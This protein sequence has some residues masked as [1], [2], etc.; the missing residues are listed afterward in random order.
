MFL[1]FYKKCMKKRLIFHF[2]LTDNWMMQKTNKIH[3]CCLK[4]FANLFNEMTFVV[5]IDD[6]THTDLIYGFEDFIIKLKICTNIKFIVKSNTI[7]RDSQT[8]YDEI[9]LKLKE[10]DGLTFFAHNKGLT[11][12]D[13][14]AFKKENV[15]KWITSM[16]YGCLIRPE[17]SEYEL[18]DG[19]KVSY[20]TLFDIIKDDYGHREQLNLHL[21][22]RW[23]FYM[24]T[25]FWLNC[26][27][28]DGFL[29]R[30]GKTVPTITDRWYAENF[31][32][33]IIDEKHC[34]SFDTRYM[35]D[36]LGGGWGE[37]DNVLLWSFG[38]YLEEY[39]NFHNK[40]LENI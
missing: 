32:A 22:D 18:T 14:S 36:Y 29:R 34:G 33:N 20:G 4:Y 21:G 37:M 31:L 8:F 6:L 9:V 15:E 40:I 23:F 17:E 11:N 2:Y 28:I 24:G 10:L 38:P 35:I 25:F 5:V 26:G 12:Y 13:D 27:V 16:Y 19:R 3:L 39:L 1:F 30:S 7:F